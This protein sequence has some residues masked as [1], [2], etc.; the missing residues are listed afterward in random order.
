MTVEVKGPETAK[1]ATPEAI[2]ARIAERIKKSKSATETDLL[3]EIGLLQERLAATQAQFDEKMGAIEAM[4]ARI[5]AIQKERSGWEERTLQRMEA[6]VA[7]RDYAVTVLQGTIVQMGKG[8]RLE[9][10]T[11]PVR[12]REG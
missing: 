11:Q 3:Y 5:I 4:N 2:K 9:G 12:A 6:K 8:H 7:A 1:P 10:L